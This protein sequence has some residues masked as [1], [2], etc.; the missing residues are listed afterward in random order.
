MKVSLFGFASFTAWTI[1]SLPAIAA[2]TELAG[3]QYAGVLTQAIT[4]SKARFR[5]GDLAGA[6]AA[7]FTLSKHAS[8][9]PEGHR[10]LGRALIGV[11][12]AFHQDGDPRNSVKAAQL[13]LGE[14]ELTLKDPGASI[15]T[16][17]SAYALKGFLLQKFSPD[18]PAAE[19][20][21]AAAIGLSP[22]STASA[23]EAL[24]R[25]KDEDRVLGYHGI[26]VNAGN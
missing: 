20:A 18:R 1:L 13:A 10:D 25:M 8:D 22:G 2:S 23:A 24:R 26:G 14:L 16:K 4:L 11:A 15:K 5:L 3:N 12:A 19:A 17:A 7:L 9:S 21:Y 6:K